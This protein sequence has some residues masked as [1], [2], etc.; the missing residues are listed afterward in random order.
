M[1]DPI[2]ME[3]E[4]CESQL[5]VDVEKLFQLVPELTPRSREEVITRVGE[6][7]LLLLAVSNGEVVGFKL[8]YPLSSSIFYSWV[9]GVAP[10]ARKRGIA[11]RLLRA[12]EDILQSRGF[13]TIR[14]K[15]VER[16][17]SMRSLLAQSGYQLIRVEGS[18][19]ATR[20]MVFE[21]RLN[22]PSADCTQK[23]KRFR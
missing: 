1:A 12:Q 5:P 22:S 11:R 19:P 15:S 8:G 20:K 17:A 9:G 18:D 14:V 13:S 2:I 16:F 23:A 3:I 10:A 21:K 6:N 7:Y 4:I